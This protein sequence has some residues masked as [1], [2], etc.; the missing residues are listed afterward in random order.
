MI[1]KLFGDK[2][3]FCNYAPSLIKMLY[4]MKY[5][6]EPLKLEAYSA[7]LTQQSHSIILCVVHS[8]KSQS[9]SFLLVFER[10]IKH[11]GSKLLSLNTY[12]L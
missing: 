3:D 6:P 9:P 8:D 4:N 2:A 7:K 1:N 5:L 10:R 12:I 11:S